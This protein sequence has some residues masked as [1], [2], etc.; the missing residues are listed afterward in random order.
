[1]SILDENGVRKIFCGDWSAWVTPEVGMNLICIRYKGE[2]LL[3]TPPSLEF[4]KDGNQG[5]YGNPITLPPN[6]TAG[7]RFEFEGTEYD[8]GINEIARGNN[9]HGGQGIQTREFTVVSTSETE[10]CAEYENHG[11]PYPFDFKATVCV[12]VS[13]QGVG[14]TVCIT[15]IGDKNMPLTFGL[16]TVFAE[17]DSFSVPIAECRAVNE[18]L[19]PTGRLLPLNEEQQSLKDGSYKGGTSLDTFFTAEGHT[20][21]IGDTR[22]SV[23]DNFDSWIIWNGDTK[24]HFIAIEPQQGAPNAL[25]SKDGLISLAPG[26]SETFTI[27]ISK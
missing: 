6:R 25:N 18:N 14:E 13:E 27:S 24:S 15:N 2:D 8:I 1:V 16:H 5:I 26:A 10:I 20:A 9:L 11:A 12:N 23:S 21:L 17:K 19:I 7:G 4:F 22:F 3:R